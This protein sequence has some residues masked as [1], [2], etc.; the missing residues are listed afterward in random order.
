[1]DV[2]YDAI[3]NRLMVICTRE[4]DAHDEI[5]RSSFVFYIGVL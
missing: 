1:M 2:W 5:L 3:E 4:Y